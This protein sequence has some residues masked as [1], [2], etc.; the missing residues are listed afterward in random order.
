MDLKYE[1]GIDDARAYSEYFVSYNAAFNRQISS[2]RR[3]YIYSAILAVIAIGLFAW[4]GQ[5]ITSIVFGAAAVGFIAVYFS[6][7]YFSRKRALNRLV[8]KSTQVL[9]GGSSKQKLT[10]TDQGMVYRTSSG[11]SDF[12]WDKLESL[13]NTG[14]HLFFMVHGFGAVIVPRRAF[15]TEMDF[16]QLLNLVKTHFTKV[17]EPA[18]RIAG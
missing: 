15:T 9:K 2:R 14:Q 6:Y 1:I 3:R 16:Q 12:K 5:V 8:K 13:V 4:R 10:V 11:E 18:N 17:E 7:P